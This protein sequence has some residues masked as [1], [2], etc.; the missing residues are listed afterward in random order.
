V[1][2]DLYNPLN[3][4]GDEGERMTNQ[5][6]DE[7]PYGLIHMPV[8]IWAV[9]RPEGPGHFLGITLDYY[10]WK[11]ESGVSLFDGKYDYRAM[12]RKV[13]PDMETALE[14]EAEK[15]VGI[16]RNSFVAHTGDYYYYNNGEP[17]IALC[18]DEYF[19][20]A[21]GETGV[22]VPV[23][24]A[25]RALGAEEVKMTEDSHIVIKFS[26]EEYITPRDDYPNMPYLKKTLTYAGY[27]AEISGR[28]YI[29]DTESG[30][31]IILPKDIAVEDMKDSERKQLINVASQLYGQ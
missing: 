30:I 15:Y 19:Y 7:L 2:V 20:S 22:Y 18:E 26:G 9:D 23:A 1:I 13:I 21:F 31:C 24:E 6:L 10:L 11:D 8:E 17:G 25:A 29:E 12:N 14:E 3:Y 28:E 16:I 4:I 27:L 5:G